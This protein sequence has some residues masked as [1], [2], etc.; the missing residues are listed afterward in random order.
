MAKRVRSKSFLVYLSGLLLV[1]GA[2]V[3]GLRLSQQKDARLLASR[4]ALADVVAH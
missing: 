1:A 4:E 2:I 3:A